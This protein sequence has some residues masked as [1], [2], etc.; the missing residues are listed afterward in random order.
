MKP[1]VRP[2]VYEVL[3]GVNGKVIHA[4]SISEAE[5]AYRDLIKQGATPA[6]YLGAML[7]DGPDLRKL[8]P[9]APTPGTKGNPRSRKDC[10]PWVGR[11][12]TA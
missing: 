5:R 4:H 6:I 8:Q 3:T 11:R 10:W 9:A 12:Q 2:G 7:I 1:L